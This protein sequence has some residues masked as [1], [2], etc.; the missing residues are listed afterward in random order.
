MCSLTRLHETRQLVALALQ[1]LQCGFCFGEA[2]S[3]ALANRLGVSGRIGAEREQV[4]D[5][6]Q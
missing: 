6:R 4:P 3:C 5:L 1:I 2:L